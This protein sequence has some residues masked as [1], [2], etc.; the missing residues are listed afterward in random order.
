MGLLKI[1]YHLTG[2]RISASPWGGILKVF[3][4]QLEQSP[5]QPLPQV[6]F[7]PASV[8]GPSTRFEELATPSVLPALPHPP[9]EQL[10]PQ[11]E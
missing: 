2:G 3:T 7:T 5:L 9:Q 1:Y 6:D 8:F 10:P 11:A 4:P